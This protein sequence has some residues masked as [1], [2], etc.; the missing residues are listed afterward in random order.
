MIPKRKPLQISR[1]PNKREMDDMKVNFYA[2]LRNVVGEKTV[3][4]PMPEGTTV[5]SLLAEMIAQYPRLKTELLNEKGELYQHV[6]I[7]VNGR[8]A[9][10][11][12]HGME[13][14]IQPDDQ[15]GVFPAVGG[16]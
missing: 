7:F 9:T 10:F 5:R 16:G 11:L 15:L 6:H 3:N 13:T 2:T 8:D 1:A 14:V 12:E 4:F